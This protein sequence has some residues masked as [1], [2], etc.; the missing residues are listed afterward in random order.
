MPIYEFECKKCDK[1]YSELTN[2]DETGKYSKVKC[3][4]CKS[5]SKTKVMSV[6]SYKFGNPIGTD[7]WASDTVGHDYRHNWN[8]DRPGGVREQRRM[9]E[10]ASHVGPTP[11]KDTTEQDIQ[12]DGKILDL[13]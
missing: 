2:F 13:D 1:K 9:A 11:Y 4:V 6:A 12:L 7:K 8:M 3:P 5:K 10:A